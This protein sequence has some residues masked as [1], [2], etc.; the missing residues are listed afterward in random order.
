MLMQR[1]TVDLR[2]VN[3]LTGFEPVKS[4]KPTK[5][6]HSA[7]LNTHNYTLLRESAD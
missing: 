6:I 3:R 5:K 4:L 2:T 1:F 7:A